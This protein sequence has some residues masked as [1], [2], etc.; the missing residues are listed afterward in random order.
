MIIGLTGGIATGKST[1]SSY[2][3]EAGLNVVCADALARKAVALGTPALAEIAEVF[4]QEY[5]LEDGNMNRRK[6]ADL[7]FS[8]KN[9]REQLEEIVHPEVQR[10]AKEE[11]ARI[12]DKVIIYD[13]ALLF[14]SK[15]PV[16][17]SILIALSPRA[18]ICRLMKRNMLTEEQAKA[19]IAV[20]MSM[21]RKM[22]Y[23]DEIVWN[24]STIDALKSNVFK[25]VE[26]LAGI[27]LS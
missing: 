18:Q 4:G 3:R 9:S 26:K 22:L 21:L 10:L 23:A 8:D 24:D 20:Q 7:I 25:A 27:K 6:M 16:D 14:E 12:G 15:M 17:F 11:F 19:R 13:S 5:L 1:A 2:L